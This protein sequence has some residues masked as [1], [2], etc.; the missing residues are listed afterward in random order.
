[1]QKDLS[2]NELI[3]QLRAGDNRSV[4][5]LYRRF[6][7]SVEY[8]VLRNNGDNDQAS[9]LFQ[10]TLVVLL[11]SLRDP[12]FRLTSSLKTY[13][14]AISRNL[15]L[16]QLRKSARWTTLEAV[17][18]ERVATA[19]ADSESSPGVYQTVMS[20]MIKLTLRCMK[21]LSSI[22]FDQKGMTQIMKDDGYTSL[23]SAQNQKYKCL[24]QARKIGK[25]LPNE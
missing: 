25:S 5:L 6:Y 19:L 17:D 1:M 15:W 16:K 10:E 8:F 24:Q 4:D 23:H 9:D 20:I 14:F 22:F 21:L 11:T 18:E 2:E 13:V 7:P 12:S 3:E